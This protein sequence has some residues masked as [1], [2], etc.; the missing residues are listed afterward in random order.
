MLLYEGHGYFLLSVFLFVISENII[1]PTLFDKIQI[2][3]PVLVS[4]RYSEHDDAVAPE[5]YESLLGGDQ[6]ISTAH[7]ACD[8]FFRLTS[9]FFSFVF[10][11]LA[12]LPFFNLQ[13]VVFHCGK[14]C[15][16]F[17]RCVASIPVWPLKARRQECKARIQRRIILCNDLLRWYWRWFV[18]LW[19]V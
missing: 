2:S 14:S 10:F 6:S 16:Y 12:L 1:F 18:L 9:C 3:S 8:I 13:H 5:R 4:F 15:S 17:L 11:I 7:A 19:S